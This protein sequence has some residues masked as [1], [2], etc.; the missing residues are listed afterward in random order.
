MSRYKTDCCIIETP[1]DGGKISKSRISL[2]QT[3][4]Y[5]GKVDNDKMKF[6]QVANSSNIQFLSR[7]KFLYM[8][9]NYYNLN[10]A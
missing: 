8:Y 5:I 4:K 2:Y 7:R 10:F 3:V 1:K 6:E 9:Y